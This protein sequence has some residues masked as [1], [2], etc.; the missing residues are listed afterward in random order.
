MNFINNWSQPVTLATGAT[1]LA[2]D[3]PDGEYRLT[4]AD[5]PF[6]Q[7]RW[8]IVGAS[9]AAGT[10]TLARGLEG[11]ADQDWPE[12]SFIYCALTA[13][14]LRDLFARLEA[15]ESP[16]PTATHQLVA[17]Q[18]P[19]TS[20]VGFEYEGYGNY[21]ALTPA[22]VVVGGID[23]GI[24]MLATEAVMSGMHLTLELS[25]TV[26][27]DL[28]IKIEGIMPSGQEWVEFSIENDNYQTVYVEY[29]SALADGQSYDVWI[30]DV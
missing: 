4:L 23:L 8:E 9:V 30:E 7:T 21:G 17:A 6:M 22:S 13:G 24:R 18:S 19:F 10:A 25:E 2:L 28:R 14:V 26:T 5:S 16:A 29:M 11:T 20:A 12:G 3:L 15:L 1:S 27:A